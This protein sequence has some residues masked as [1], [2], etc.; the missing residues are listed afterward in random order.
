MVSICFYSTVQ[1]K[2]D[3]HLTT[4]SV[5]RWVQVEVIAGLDKGKQGVVKDVIKERNLLVVEGVRVFTRSLAPMPLYKE[6]KEG[7][8]ISEER[9]LRYEE[10]ML[11]DPQ[12]K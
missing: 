6:G 1:L 8:L 3:S 10:V 9:A 5:C 7:G 11:V 4:E 12:L 2:K